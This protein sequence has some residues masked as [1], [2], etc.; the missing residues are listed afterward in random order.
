MA[1][2]KILVI[3]DSQTI[4]TMLTDIL[5]KEKYKVIPAMTGE[6]GLKKASIEPPHVIILDIIMPIMDGF[7]VC[8]RLKGDEKTRSIPVILLT[9]L[10]KVT[11]VIQ[12]LEV[13]ADNFITKSPDMASY[14]LGRVR[15]ILKEPAI[16]KKA[17]LGEKI[18][19]KLIFAPARKQIFQLLVD[20]INKV[21]REEVVHIIGQPVLTAIAKRAVEK[22]SAK[23]DFLQK[24]E[25]MPN[26]IAVPNMEEV[27]KDISAKDLANG[28]KELVSELLDILS[29]LTG[30]ILVKKLEE[31]IEK[32]VLKK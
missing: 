6:E 7:E 17:E 27:V 16:R 8:K 21:V 10:D 4:I 12:G 25:V 32:E 22:V 15:E 23:Y 29:K 26:G 28:T 19:E 30:S 5:E 3:D 20:K 13:G 1:N 18:G 24:M 9:Q 14:L 31:E 2:E 11:D